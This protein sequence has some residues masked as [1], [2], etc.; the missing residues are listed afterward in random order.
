MLPPAERG[1]CCLRPNGCDGEYLGPVPTSVVLPRTAPSLVGKGQ[2]DLRKSNAKQS[3]QTSHEQCHSTGYFTCYMKVGNRC[4]TILNAVITT[5][6]LWMLQDWW[7]F[8][9]LYIRKTIFLCHSLCKFA[10]AN[11]TTIFFPPNS[12]NSDLAFKLVTKTGDDL[13]LS[14]VTVN[15]ITFD[16]VCVKNKQTNHKKKKITQGVIVNA[17]LLSRDSLHLHPLLPLTLPPQAPLPRGWMDWQTDSE[18][19][20]PASLPKTNT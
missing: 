19:L 7:W 5:N 4:N 17:Y 16:I 13:S 18:N 9:K 6:T 11:N 15:N 14:Q 12:A 1:C 3:A 2:L 8:I 10:W 20:G